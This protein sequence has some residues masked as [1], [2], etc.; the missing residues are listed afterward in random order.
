ML[1]AGKSGK[2][3]GI[4]CRD[5]AHQLAIGDVPFYRLIRENDL[6]VTTFTAWRAPADAAPVLYSLIETIYMVAFGTLLERETSFGSLRSRMMAGQAFGIIDTDQA[7]EPANDMVSINSVSEKHASFD[8]YQLRERQRQ[9]EMRG[10]VRTEAKEE[11]YQAKTAAMEEIGDDSICPIENCDTVLSP[12]K[13]TFHKVL[14]AWICIQCNAR[15]GKARQK[16]KLTKPEVCTTEWCERTDKLTFA[17]KEDFGFCCYKCIRMSLDQLREQRPTVPDHCM[18]CDKAC[19]IR[20]SDYVVRLQK[21]CCVK[22]FSA[23]KR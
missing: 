12:Q 3:H 7:F 4:L 20:Y 19:A 16:P 1:H 6:E 8:E 10:D 9:F 21:W 13:R 11:H 14:K 5:E 23:S 18:Q 2:S 22:C 17:F 15:G